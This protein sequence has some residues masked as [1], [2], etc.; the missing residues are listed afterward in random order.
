M[1]FLDHRPYYLWKYP[2]CIDETKTSNCTL[3]DKPQRF[4]WNNKLQKLYTETL[5]QELCSIKWKDF[6]E[7]LTNKIEN[8]NLETENLLS[9]VED[10]SLNTAGEVLRK[11]RKHKKSK[12][13][14]R[15]IKNK[16]WFSKACNDK[17][18]E[19]KIILKSLNRN[20]NNH[21]LRTKFYQLR[22]VYKSLCR[23]LK[24]K[25]D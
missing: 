13:K 5:E 1:T 11:T 15:K 3:E 24:Y 12:V 6:D 8:I 9:N 10:T 23:K 18:K 20:L 16:I 7:L 17:Y 19:L 21:F 14:N 22:K 4:I 2:T 25:Y